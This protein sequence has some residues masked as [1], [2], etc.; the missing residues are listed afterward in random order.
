MYWKKYFLKTSK[1]KTLLDNK[2]EEHFLSKPIW[3][4]RQK[5]S[6]TKLNS[7]TTRSSASF[8]YPKRQLWTYSLQCLGILTDFEKVLIYWFYNY[9]F[10][11][12]IY[13]F[14][15]DNVIHKLMCEIYSKLTIEKPERG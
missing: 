4:T 14:K 8:W 15:I 12:G 1:R 9:A 3:K 11:A 7:V 10:P 5:S 6:I 13:L 2:S